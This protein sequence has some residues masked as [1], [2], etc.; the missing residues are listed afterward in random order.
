MR[1]LAVFALVAG[2]LAAQAAPTKVT[3][4]EGI[5]EYRLSNGLDVLLFPDNS[6]PT[7][8]VNITYLVGS[9]QEGYGE[10]G[11]AH[12][13]EHMMFKGTDKHGEIL[14][15]L[16]ARGAQANA[17]TS[18]DRTNYFETLA[19]TDDNLR[20]AL[21]MEA[22]RMIHSRIAQKDLDSEMTVVRNEFERG[23][24]SPPEIL[25]ERVFST[26]YLWH[27]Y[28]RSPIG[29][30]SDIEHVPAT[31]LKVFYREYYQPD[32]AILV[33]A[34]KFDP[35]KTLGWVEDSFGMIPKPTRQLPATYTVEPVQ[36][37]ERE[38][39][40][41]RVGNQQIVMMAYHIPAGSDPDSAPLEVLAGIL[42]D[43][44][45]GRLYKALVETKKAVS[46]RAEQEQMH[47]P[48]LFEFSATVS[49]EGSLDD[50]EKTMAS[51]IDGVIQEPPSKEEVDRA[52]TRL[53]K[54]IDLSLNNSSRIGLNL[55]EWASMGDWRLL[56]LFRDR[57]EK[58]T[59]A[60]VARVAKAYFKK[61]N[62]T[63]GLFIP[64]AAPDRAVIPPVPNIEAVLKGYKGKPAI[65]AGE[66]FNPTPANIEARIKRMTLPG[67]L[68]LVLL[69]KKTRGATVT[70]TLALHFGD[71]KSLFGKEAAAQMAG[72]LLMRGT[73]KHTR[74]QIQDE[75]DRLKARVNVNGG[76]SGAN[77]SINTVRESLPDALRLAA[78][79]LRQPAFPEKDFDQIRQA[80]LARI[81]ASRTDP[82]AIAVNQLNRHISQYP[83]GDPRAVLTPDQRM[84]EIKQATLADA[85][86]FYSDFYG[87]SNAELA[88]VGDF[89][90]AE[91]EK[92]AGELFG[93]WESPQP[94]KEIT[95][96]WR[97]VPVVDQAIETPDKAN[98][99]F[100]MASTVAMSQ[101]DPDYPTMVVVNELTGGDAKSRLWT[102]VRE[103]AGLS[104]SVGSSFS[105]DAQHPYGRFLGSAICNPA[106]IE[107]VESAFKEELGKIVSEGFTEQEVD[108]AKKGLLEDL[109]LGRSQDAGLAR[110]LA[111]EAHY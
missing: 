53:L 11:M 43:Q 52:R 28:G 3:S 77:A 37:G 85:K 14:A 34:G 89:D 79:I 95:Q 62:R 99:I 72:S 56:F 75:L 36:D 59:P 18:Y 2:L 105:A 26:A 5:T 84:D 32:D 96:D 97:K 69:P 58:V 78:E 7:V 21:D 35:T 4:V 67:G 92:L 71:V 74:Q 102:R 100:L 60:D 61:S 109:Q 45:S 40:L 13:L 41:R 8:T 19:A 20:W 81:E 22:D 104:Y 80:T 23:E 103:K 111:T 42:S 88:V 110:T 86:K 70:A 12:L 90:P 6:K 30:R 38:V 68:K 31:K 64:A 83:V 107:K 50:A 65:Q 93:D 25:E 63:I 9:R 39:T 66:A 106:N 27:A 73:Q 16:T 55:S 94:Y 57:I 51:V 10:T 24:N 87:A 108:A 1:I 17:T 44:P 98:A 82:Q 49:K 33:V 91:V 47:D 15:E 101:D 29:S 76:V 46:A 54:D 48:G